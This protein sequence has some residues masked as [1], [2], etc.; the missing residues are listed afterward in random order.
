MSS[1]SHMTGSYG[2]FHGSFSGGT[3]IV[4]GPSRFEATEA[5]KKTETSAPKMPQ[6]GESDRYLQSGNDSNASL[7]LDDIIEEN[8]SHSSC[9]TN[10]TGRLWNEGTPVSGHGV[11]MPV[12]VESFSNQPDSES[13]FA[14]E[15]TTSTSLSGSSTG[16]SFY[17]AVD[18]SAADSFAVHQA[19]ARCA[20]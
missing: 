11:V 7:C 17:S 6:R 5:E 4:P 19:K 3:P 15:S 16:V 12:R 18:S 13:S 20:V 8:S 2:S 14:R 10:E 1:I 9:P